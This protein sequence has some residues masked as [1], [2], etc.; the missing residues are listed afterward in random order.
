MKKI[1]GIV[2]LSLF[3]C[4]ISSADL[5]DL[6]IDLNTSEK[7][8]KK[9]LIKNG[10]ASKCSS[11]LADR[12]ES[13]YLSMNLYGYS[14]KVDMEIQVKVPG[15]DSGLISIRYSAKINQDGSI[16]KKKLLENKLTGSSNFKKEMKPYMNIF[17]NLGDMVMDEQGYYPDYGKPLRATPVDI[18]GKKLF[19]RMIS[20]I[21][22]STP[23]QSGQLKKAGSHI[24]KN[25]IINVS[26]EFI[27]YSE[28][29]GERYNL[30][31]YKFKINYNGNKSEYRQ[32]AN[33]FDID[34][35]AFFH[36]SG[37]PTI[38]YDIIPY[39]ETPIHHSTICKVYKNNSLISEISVPILKDSKKLKK[40]KKKSENNNITDQLEA[41][42]N[43]YKSGVLTKEE[44]EK[45]KKRI[46]N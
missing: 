14:N 13:G 9:I 26:K 6:K 3:L 24:I 15:P 28:I 25:S 2:V 7:T 42:N 32:F 5:Y 17:K 10:Y 46:L 19:K 8:T 43:L 40:I 21:A 36:E 12:N 16:N 33:Q 30:I 37:L 34:Q 41:L 31:R 29:N 20:L 22:K 11:Y 38:V 44:F 4:N 18:D 35:I 1:L 23:K 39:S 27:G 45:A